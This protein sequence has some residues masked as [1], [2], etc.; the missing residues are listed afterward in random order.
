VRATGLLSRQWP[1]GATTGRRVAPELPIARAVMPRSGT[2][3][4]GARGQSV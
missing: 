4:T 3:A 2:L 1:Y